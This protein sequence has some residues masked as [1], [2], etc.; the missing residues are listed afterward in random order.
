[1]ALWKP[2][3]LVGFEGVQF[4]EHDFQ[5]EPLII[6]DSDSETKDPEI[7]LGKSNNH[8]RNLNN[9]PVT[10]SSLKTHKHF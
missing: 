6:S 8:R 4:G 9:L 3:V 7:D 2:Y 5:E 1:M 10:T